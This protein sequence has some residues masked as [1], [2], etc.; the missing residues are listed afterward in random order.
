MKFKELAEKEPKALNKLLIDTR[1][2]LMKDRFA[3]AGRELANVSEIN[4][5]RKLIAK[6]KTALRQREIVATQEVIA[7]EQKKQGDK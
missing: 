7:K 4:K 6:I 3:V 1:A 2:K 5:S